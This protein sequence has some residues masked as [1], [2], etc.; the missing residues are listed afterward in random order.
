MLRSLCS[1]DLKFTV[2]LL[3]PPKPPTPAPALSVPPPPSPTKSPGR[4]FRNVFSSPKK[5]VAVAPHRPVVVP[6]P[7]PFYD[8][9]TPK[10]QLARLEFTFL[11]HAAKCRL[12]KM[13]L[14]VPF[15][16]PDAPVSK[17][18]CRGSMSMDV[19][20]LPGVPGIPRTDLPQSMHDVVQ[21]LEA[22]AQAT[23]ITHEGVLTQLGGDCTVR[24][25]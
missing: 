17:K 6:A 14:T 4:G 10:G 8:Y 13:R 11:D 5:K 1:E 12:R 9:V 24:M 19:L 15:T 16:V 2:T 7:D 3:V 23:K 18:V 21:G 25:I 20:W 22:A